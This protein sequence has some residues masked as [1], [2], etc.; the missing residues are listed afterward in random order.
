MKARLAILLAVS[1]TACVACSGQ[2]VKLAQVGGE[3]IEVLAALPADARPRIVVA[4]VR[5]N[6]RVG[7]FSALEA[8]LAVGGHDATGSQFLGGVHDLL[9]TGLLNTGAFT[10]LERNDLDELSRERIMRA[11]QGE[12]VTLENSLEGADLVVAAALTSFEPSGGSSI[13]IPVPLGDDHFGIIWVKRGTSSLAMDL[14]VLDVRTGRVVH[15]NA[16]RGQARRFGIDFDA[17][18]NISDSYLTLP[19]VLNYFNNTPMHTAILE[20]VVLT[21]GEVAQAAQPGPVAEAP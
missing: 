10:V 13:P 4:P 12:Q 8:A 11:E 21:V 7:Q 15:S 18:I 2:Q 20:M 14:R 6:T 9:I 1:I 17:F 3:A 5:D 19:G 16:V